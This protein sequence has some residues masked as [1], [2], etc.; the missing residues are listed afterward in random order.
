VLESAVH[1]ADAVL[2]GLGP[3]SAAD[4]GITAPGT[5]AVVRA[6]QATGVRRVVVVSAAPVGTVPSPGHPQPHGTTPATGSSCRTGSAVSSGRRSAGTTPTRADGGPPVRQRPGLDRGPAAPADRQAAERRLP[7]GVRAERPR[8]LAA[9]A[10]RCRPPDYALH[11]AGLLPVVCPVGDGSGV[12]GI[13]VFDASPE[14]V[15]RI[16]ANDP[17]VRA[18]VFSLRR[19]LDQELSGGAVSR[20]RPRRDRCAGS[21]AP[22]WRLAPAAGQS[23]GAARPP[24]PGGPPSSPI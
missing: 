13:S 4:A 8:R 2:S 3:R 24:P 10:G 1:G 6:M 14:D 15:D 17:G 18:G 19:P 22:P 12:T 20:H 11:L 9:V 21:A 7:D 23:L 16:M 5:K